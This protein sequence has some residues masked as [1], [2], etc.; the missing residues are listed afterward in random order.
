MTVGLNGCFLPEDLVVYM[1]VIIIRVVLIML[2]VFIFI[3]AG[4]S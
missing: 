3:F 4:Y 2:S 1:L